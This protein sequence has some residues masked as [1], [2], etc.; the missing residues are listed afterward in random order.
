MKATGRIQEI[1]LF[2]AVLLILAHARL[3]K[4]GIEL[5]RQAMVNFFSPQFETRLMPWIRPVVSMYHPLDDLIPFQPQVVETYLGFMKFWLKTL[6]YYYSRLG[7][8]VLPDIRSAIDGL[9]RIYREVGSI[10]RT[11]QSTTTTRAALRMNPSFLAICLLDPHL[12]C[13]PSLHILIVCYNHY[14]SEEIL[15][16]HGKTGEELA[17]ALQEVYVEALRITEAILLVKQHSILDIAPSLFMVSALFESYGREKVERFIEGLF[18]GCGLQDWVREKLRA[19][20]RQSYLELMDR[21]ESA[22]DRGYREVILDFLY[23]FGVK[24]NSSWR[25]GSAFREKQQA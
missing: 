25:R 3:L 18:S 9:C 21:V 15:A 13:I 20:I 2:R 23:R 12:H 11:C 6:F 5:L 19:Y 1:R 7:K 17:P 14:K 10:Y 8:D 16:R 4:R 24:K 22:K